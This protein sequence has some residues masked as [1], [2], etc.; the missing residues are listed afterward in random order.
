MWIGIHYK[1]VPK[2]LKPYQSPT[3]AA[4]YLSNFPA[5]APTQTKDKLVTQK[6]TW[7]P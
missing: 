4:F 2:K 5:P 3:G 1:T 6:P 7:I